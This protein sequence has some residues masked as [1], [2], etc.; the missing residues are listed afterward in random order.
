MTDYSGV[1]SREEFGDDLIELERVAKEAREGVYKLKLFVTGSTPRS[2]KAVSNVRSICE[3]HLA[4]RYHLEVIDLYQ[5]PELAR[6]EQVLAA[7]TL[8]RELPEPIRKVVGDMS[9]EDKVLY[10][11]NI[12]RT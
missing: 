1:P 2:T 7:P 6:E 3:E 8:V 10:S 9:N 11:L 4:G 12:D 5:R